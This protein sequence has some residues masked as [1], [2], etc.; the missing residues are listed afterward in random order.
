MKAVKGYRYLYRRGDQLYFR[1]RVPLNA[2][3]AFD[4]R[5]EVQRSLGTGNIAEARHLLAIE[6]AAFDK[7]VA[8][9][10]GLPI[11]E[12][13]RQIVPR[14]QPTA[15]ELEEIVRRW[16]ARRLER[17][18]E[19]E[20]APTDSGAAK[21]LRDGLVG[22]SENVQRGISLGAD[23]PA[24]TTIWLA[25][26]VCEAEGWKIER[27]SSLWLQLVRLLGRGQIEANSWLAADLNGEGRVVRDARFAPEQYGLDKQR[28]V[29]RAA[30]APVSILSMLEGYLRE[31]QPKPATE[32]V[33]RRHITHFIAFLG[34]EDAARVK[35]PDV[36][37]WKDS[38]LE[39][40][41]D[42][43]KAKSIRTVRD[44]YLPAVRS[45]FKWGA[46]NGKITQNPAESVRVGGKRKPP[47][48]DRGF[49]D[50]E[51]ELILSATH[52]AAC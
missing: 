41:A 10:A 19:S 15:I 6:V 13:L 28:Q 44:S 3:A 5:E 30:H 34:H 16:L 49:T 35:L 29:E 39:E 22:H 36:V 7:N 45:V 37:A 21:R 43:R 23:Q 51:A 9:A 8:D 25:E 17:A 24:I 40:P 31:H 46:G 42:G 18:A 4:G 32:K 12:A 47:A 52:S 48:R 20:L 26:S 2:N 50:A 14:G 1:R 27:G 33:W 38:L 11:T